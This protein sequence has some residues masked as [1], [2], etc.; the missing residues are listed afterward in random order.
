MKAHVCARDL[1]LLAELRKEAQRRGG[2][3]D[4]LEALKDAA[5]R[6]RVVQRVARVC[7]RN[8]CGQKDHLI[9]DVPEDAMLQLRGLGACLKTAPDGLPLCNPLS[10]VF[11]RRKGNATPTKPAAFV[12]DFPH[13]DEVL[14][15]VPVEEPRAAHKPH[16]EPPKIFDQ[17]WRYVEPK[18]LFDDSEEGGPRAS[19]DAPRE[20]D[21]PR[22]FEPDL[23][24]RFES[25]AETLHPLSKGNHHAKFH[26]KVT[27]LREELEGQRRV[28]EQD[29]EAAVDSF[30][31]VAAESVRHRKRAADCQTH[32]KGILADLKAER[33]ALAR[34]NQNYNELSDSYGA[35]RRLYLAAANGTH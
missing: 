21:L 23:P 25:E 8:R 1:C 33:S 28:H 32:L 12:N 20:K 30:G 31:N 15:H 3:V 11:R 17:P 34:C 7:R 19:R 9:W 4:P 14:R 26:R 13:L 10:G 2:A 22:H 27:A 29:I 6:R 18:H 24:R 35:L 16:R 5:F